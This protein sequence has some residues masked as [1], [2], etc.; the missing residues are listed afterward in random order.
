[1]KAFVKSQFK[2]C[3]L[4]WMF[5]NRALNNRIIKIPEL[6]L[7]LVHQNKNLSFS[8]LLELD[9]AVTIHHINLLVLVTKIFKVENNLSPAIM[10]QIFDFLEPYYNPRSET[11]Q[12][13]KENITATHYGIQS[14]NFLGP[15][16]WAW[17]L[18]ILKTANVYKNLRDWLKYGNLKLALAKCSKSML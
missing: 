2:Y 14:V 12:F 16:I 9:N 11:S 17:Y 7:W 6:T 5:D 10:K 4:I 3:T 15:K 8:E 18:K 1:M 13:S